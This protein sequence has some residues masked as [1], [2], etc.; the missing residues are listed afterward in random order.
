M[1]LASAGFDRV[2]VVQLGEGSSNG[3]EELTESQLGEVGVQNGWMIAPVGEDNGSQFTQGSGRCS[4]TKP[5]AIN[6]NN[7]I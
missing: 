3:R 5:S 6:T 1:V 4:S 2:G 7:F